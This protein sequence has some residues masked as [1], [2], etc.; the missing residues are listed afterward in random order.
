MRGILALLLLACAGAAQ[1]QTARVDRVDIA[2]YGLYTAEVIRAERDAQGLLRSTSGNIQHTQS[3]RTVP[4]QLGV[5]FGF[6]FKVVGAPDGAEV[7]LREITTFPAGGLRKPG[8]SQPLTRS[9]R[10]L[11]VKIGQTGYNAYKFDDPWELVPGVWTME[12]WHEGAK[13]ASLA[14][15]VV[16]P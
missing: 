7:R 3:T 15:T 5:R 14:F 6:R 11:T 9:E 4:A 16:K 12:L 10:M 1:S 13:V 2:D 8:S